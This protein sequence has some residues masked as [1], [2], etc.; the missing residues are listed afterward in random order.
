MSELIK[1]ALG[2]KSDT[3]RRAYE[4]ELERT[5]ERLEELKKIAPATESDLG[6]TY[7]N[8]LEK[9]VQLVKSP[10]TVWKSL[11]VREQHQVFFLLF[12]GKLVYSKTEAYRNA[13]N[14]S[15][16]RLF[17]ELA[18]ANP[19]DVEVDTPDKN[20]AAGMRLLTFLTRGR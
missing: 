16:V 15:S 1:A 7:R 3:S 14:L 19:H 17:E 18:L 6:A 2:A 20:L 10:Y 4:I 12:E 9:A 11:S 13:K 8:S 5:S